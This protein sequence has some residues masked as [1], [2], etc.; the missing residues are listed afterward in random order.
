MFNELEIVFMMIYYSFS[1]FLDHHNIF[2]EGFW[3]L[4]LKKL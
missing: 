2:S 3:T 1:A 4:N